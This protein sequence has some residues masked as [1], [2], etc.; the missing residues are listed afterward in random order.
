MPYPDVG[1]STTP[2]KSQQALEK[3]HLSPGGAGSA[4]PKLDSDGVLD[5]AHVRGGQFP[6]VLLEPPFGH[7]RDLVGHH[8][9]PIAL[10]EHIGFL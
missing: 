5:G 4:D 8:L 9:A 1:R 3:A 10:D 7:R 2:S 6:D